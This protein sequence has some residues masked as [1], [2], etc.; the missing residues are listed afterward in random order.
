[1]Q[2]VAERLTTSWWVSVEC[3]IPRLSRCPRALQ[4]FVIIGEKDAAD[5]L[6]SS[7]VESRHGDQ[8]NPLRA[9][10]DR[11]RGRP[12]GAQRVEKAQRRAAAKAQRLEHKRLKDGAGGGGGIAGI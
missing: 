6:A 5:A 1:M 4:V 3:S 10:R 12:F 7:Q 8:R 9:L 2:R 11:L